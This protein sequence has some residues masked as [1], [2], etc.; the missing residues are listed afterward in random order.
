MGK[1]QKQ[2]LMF[3]VAHHLIQLY[4]SPLPRSCFP[5]D[6]GEKR[7][8]QDSPGSE[9]LSSRLGHIV[10]WCLRNSHSEKIGNPDYT[11]AALGKDPES[12]LKCSKR[13]KEE[14][15]LECY[16]FSPLFTWLQSE[17]KT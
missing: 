2:N 10:D 15:L 8:E 16:H 17:S 4:Y 12:G 6:K 11:S 14:T 3:W 1:K 13:L 9:K 5:A 7:V